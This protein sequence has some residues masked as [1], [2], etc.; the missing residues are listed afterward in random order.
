V[1]KIV[2]DANYSS[3]VG[4]HQSLPACSMFNECSACMR[5]IRPGYGTNSV[6]D[7]LPGEPGFTAVT[8]CEGDASLNHQYHEQQIENYLTLCRDQKL[9][10]LKLN[11]RNACV[12][13]FTDNLRISYTLGYYH[14]TLYY[15][16]RAGNLV[17]TVPPAG[18]NDAM[19]ASDDRSDHEMATNYTYNSIK[20]LV[21]QETP[22]GGITKFWYNA[23]GQLVL[24]QSAEQV[25]EIGDNQEE[26]SYTRYDNLGR[27]IEVGEL[28]NRHSELYDPERDNKIDYWS[29]L[30]FPDNAIPNFQGGG[31][32]G[33]T[34]IT[35]TEYGTPLFEYN[36]GKP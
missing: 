32:M 28:F 4:S 31:Y 5:W 35:V 30:S 36:G 2:F 24:S 16:D 25:K 15:H 7:L 20:Q 9:D 10:A 22:D 19:T 33:K 6:A 17:T 8:N 3:Y 1:R 21:K 14:Y 11:Y 23:N 26:F 13:N 34:D 12:N 29:T 18:V 27:I